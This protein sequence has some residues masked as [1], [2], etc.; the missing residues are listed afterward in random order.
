MSNRSWWVLQVWSYHPP[1][2]HITLKVASAE[3]AEPLPHSLD[4]LTVIE[5]ENDNNYDDLAL[6]T[7][8]LGELFNTPTVLLTG[9]SCLESSP[10]R[11]RQ[12]EH[13][14]ENTS[15]KWSCKSKQIKNSR[16]LEDDPNA[17]S[18]R[19]YCCTLEPTKCRHFVLSSSSK[20]LQEPRKEAGDQSAEVIADFENCLVRCGP[21]SWH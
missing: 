2:L 18:R 14:S 16:A 8:R 9:M 15:S 3:I 13:L 4:S 21:C 12:G 10:T 20:T 1:R 19:G 6:S 11:K 5:E 7:L 17:P